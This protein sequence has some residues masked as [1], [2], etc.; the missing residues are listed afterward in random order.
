METAPLETAPLLIVIERVRNNN[1][2]PDP[3]EHHPI[4]QTLIIDLIWAFLQPLNLQQFNKWPN[5]EDND[6]SPNIIS[7]LNQH[8]FNWI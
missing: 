3:D 1:N 5:N 2:Y 4:I 7:M 8:I 6:S